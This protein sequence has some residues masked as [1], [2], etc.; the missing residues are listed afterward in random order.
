MRKK[1]LLIT[2]YW[3]PSGGPGVQRWL[4]MS[5]YLAEMGCDISVLTIR[6]A[7]ASYPH[8]DEALQNDVH[9]N[10]RVIRTQAF[11][12]YR[13][14]NAS[15]P[16][17]RPAANFSVPKSGKF[18]FKILA[19]IRSHLFIPDPRRGW[20]RWAKAEAV[21]IC[22][23]QGIQTV[24]TTSPP[25][26]SQ[27]IGAH[28]KR[29]L[30][31]RWIADFRDPW[32][33]IFYYDSLGHSWLSKWIDKQ[34]EKRVVRLA[35]Q[36]LHVGETMVR[37]LEH[38]YP[39][40]RAKSVVVHNGFDERDF[41][42]LPDVPRTSEFHIVY[43]GTLSSMYNFQPLFKAIQRCADQ[44]DIVRC[45][46]Y[47]QV[48]DEIQ[49]ELKQLCPDVQLHGEVSHAE[50][51][52][53]QC[54]ADLLLVILPDVPHAGYILSGKVFEYLRA[55][56]RILVLGP[57]EGDAARLVDACQ[58]GQTFERHDIEAIAQF[59]SNE[60]DRKLEGRQLSSNQ[61]K[62]QEYSRESLARKVFDLL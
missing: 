60:I 39:S 11:N 31:V 35:D 17:H 28:V 47:G 14:F 7:D 37:L 2:Y 19:S 9:P 27:L 15:K 59:I 42:K 58:A 3:P 36:I 33:T 61:E 57:P 8:V 54:A 52:R 26:S 53:I 44:S 51:N 40:A 38:D 1:L 23:E 50:I 24:I 34:Y 16:G 43:T 45:S 41:A 6:E 46:I 32:T 20:N 29:V 5:H 22:K 55:G 21:R 56:S 49:N 62:V 30:G 4:K 12:P 25:H 48:P 13:I 18:L 10:I